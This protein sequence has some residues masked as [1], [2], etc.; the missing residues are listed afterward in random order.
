MRKLAERCVGPAPASGPPTT[1]AGLGED[2]SER[3]ARSVATSYTRAAASSCNT[4]ANTAETICLSEL[5][6]ST[7]VTCTSRAAAAE[8]MT[9]RTRD[10]LK[11]LPELANLPALLHQAVGSYTCDKVFLVR[12]GVVCSE[13]AWLP[14]LV[15]L[16]TVRAA[17]SFFRS[18]RFDCVE[19]RMADGSVGYGQLR[20]LFTF[21]KRDYAMVRWFDE[22]RGSDPLVKRGCP[23]LT[24]ATTGK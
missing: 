2:S 1:T 5:T 7:V 22:V 24:W 15:T 20:L 18:P 14:D 13:R 9:A 4:L 10:W 3:G 11:S 19:L 6:T 17:P 23:R 16:D 8:R 12:T 21:Q